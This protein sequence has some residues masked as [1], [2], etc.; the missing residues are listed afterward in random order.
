MNLNELITRRPPT[1]W[2]DG[3]K[4]PWHDPVFSAAMLREHLSQAHDAASRRTAII[5]RQVAWIHRHILHER[6]ARILDLGCGPGFYLNRLAGLGHTGTGI[7]F[8]PASIDYARTQ[9]A[10]DQLP[11]TYILEDVRNAA[12][13]EGYDL[14]MFLFGEFNV[15]SPDDAR[16]ILA[17]AHAALAPGGCCLLEPSTLASLRERGQLP[18]SWY[19]TTGGLFS[20]RPHLCLQ[21]N[22]WDEDA[23]AAVERYAI[24]D[25]ASATAVQY[26]TTS[27]GYSETALAGMLHAAGFSRIDSYPSLIG[28]PHPEQ[29]EF[30]AV[31]AFIC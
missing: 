28:E 25:A 12:F 24:V 15:F 1:A 10:H 26:A 13:G 16:A 30:W 22:R 17:K 9:A 11:C 21:D 20:D 2:L 8:G 31:A 18:P 3:V 6:P 27:Q 29:S 23:Q 19:A 5:D 14:V 4:I 7:D